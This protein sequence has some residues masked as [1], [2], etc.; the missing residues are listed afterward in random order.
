MRS[1]RPRCRTSSQD[2]QH[3][4]KI[5]VIFARC[6][7]S[8]GL[9]WSRP[10]RRP[11]LAAV[12][13][14]R[15]TQMA[16]PPGLVMRAAG[17]GP[18]LRQHALHRMPATRTPLGWPTRNALSWW[19]CETR[20]RG[21]RRRSRAP[22]AVGMHGRAPHAPRARLE[23]QSRDLR[24]R[25]SRRTAA[26]SSAE[27]G[28]ACCGKCRRGRAWGGCVEA[29]PRRENSASAPWSRAKRR[30]AQAASR[31]PRGLTTSRQ[32]DGHLRK[33]TCIFGRC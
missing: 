4:R 29:R 22:R 6:C 13:H 27:I 18:S 15:G 12:L 7:S 33:M 1:A 25:Q 17:D 8:L 21:C 24:E 3:L 30:E 11:G 31:R 14:V 26:G 10:P 19:A 5:H 28:G 32:D 20:A 23:L 2:A 9:G 16:R